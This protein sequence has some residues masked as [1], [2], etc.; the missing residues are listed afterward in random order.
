MEIIVELYVCEKCSHVENELNGAC[1]E[2]GGIM[3]C[4]D[5]VPRESTYNGITVGGN[6]WERSTLNPEWRDAALERQIEVTDKAIDSL[7]YELYGLS[8]EEIRIVEEK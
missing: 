7:V 5:F 3:K 6:A 4:V 8:E 1:P 2:C